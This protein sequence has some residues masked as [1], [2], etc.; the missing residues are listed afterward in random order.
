MDTGL[1]GL[2]QICRV[3]KQTKEIQEYGFHKRN[4]KYKTQCKECARK[5]SALYRQKNREKYLKTQSST[6]LKQR[7]GITLSEYEE[8]VK[9]QQNK[10]AIC[11]T[12]NPSYGHV[13]RFSVDH[14]HA[15]GRVRGLLCTR[16]NKGIGFFK[17]DINLLSQAIQY[18]REAS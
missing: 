13:K 10:C 9:N 7:Y 8:K 12:E 4:K 15:T 11:K 3:C 2:W 14:C 17:D 16:C 18:L 5:E 1:N 6:Q